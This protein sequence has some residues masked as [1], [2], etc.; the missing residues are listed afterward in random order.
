MGKSQKASKKEQTEKAK[1]KVSEAAAPEV[2]NTEASPAP[3]EKTEAAQDSKKDKKDKRKEKKEKKQK[4]KKVEAEQDTAMEVDSVKVEE[5][6]GSVEKDSTTSASEPEVAEVSSADASDSK[7]DKK[8]KDKKKKEKK[9]KDTDSKKADEEEEKAEDETKES[10]IEATEDKKNEDEAESAQKVSRKRESPEDNEK[11]NK[12]QKSD[13]KNDKRADSIYKS[14]K[15]PGIWIGNLS[16]N[17]TQEDVIEFFTSNGIEN[18]T[19]VSLPKQNNNYN[20]NTSNLIR[21]FGYVDFETV[22]VAEKAVALSECEILGRKILI[23]L[24]TDYGRKTP[25]NDYNNRNNFNGGNRNNSYGNDNNRADRP[26]SFSIVVK[27]LSFSTTKQSL[28]KLAG[29]YGDVKNVSIPT[30]RDNP[31]K[32]R[33]FC[34]FDYNDKESATSAFNS[35]NDSVFDGRKLRVEYSRNFPSE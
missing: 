4:A 26:P 27:N 7:K 17:T 22:E 35:L 31:T 23:K 32:P 24:N 8:K 10:S 30:F 19:R 16:Y 14:E 13:K 21:G 18:P 33:G 25:A 29:K 12:K 28:E 3:V 1:V 34:Y 20:N 6:T 15:Q 5:Q 2:V 9:N 11:T